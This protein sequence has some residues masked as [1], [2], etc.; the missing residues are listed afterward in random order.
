[1]PHPET[2]PYSGMD[3]FIEASGLWE[4]FHSHL[5]E[6]ISRELAIA[7]PS[8]Y[9]VRTGERSYVVLSESDEGPSRRQ[10]KPDVAVASTEE[11]FAT[12]VAVAETTDA[13]AVTMRAF[14]EESFR[15]TFVE[16]H[17]ADPQSTLVTAIEALSPSNKRKGTT[18]WHEHLRKRQA[19]LT[20]AANFIEIDLLREGRRMPMVDPW[21]DSPYYLLVAR[22]NAA[23]LCKVWPAHSMSPLPTIPVPLLPPDADAALFLQPLIESIYARFRY[24]Q[25]IDYAT[26]PP[27]LAEAERQPLA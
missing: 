6:E 8:R 20:G 10:F 7:L 1:M 11:R 22:K 27:S 12:G 4:D 15:E 9:L 17:Q 13:T 21:P 25:S 5:I 19:L 24:R 16:I 14:V 2:S 26:V 3:P 18:G 23:P